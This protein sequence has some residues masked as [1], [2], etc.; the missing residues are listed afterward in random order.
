MAHATIV[1]ISFVMPSVGLDDDSIPLVQY[2]LRKNVGSGN[3]SAA[4][5]K[6]KADKP[7][8]TNDWYLG[9][10]DFFPVY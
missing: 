4:T 10:V 6:S 7:C 3:G 1:A 5:E 8:S 2:R 9:V